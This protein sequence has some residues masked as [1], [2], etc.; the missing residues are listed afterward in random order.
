MSDLFRMMFRHVIGG[1]DVVGEAPR[2]HD[3]A[4]VQLD[5]GVPEARPPLQVEAA[6]PGAGL[7]LQIHPPAISE[8]SQLIV[9]AAIEKETALLP[10]SQYGGHGLPGA[11]HWDVVSRVVTDQ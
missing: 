4:V 1:E 7:L 2:H 11:T 3:L 10:P 8:G 5:A 6:H 9:E